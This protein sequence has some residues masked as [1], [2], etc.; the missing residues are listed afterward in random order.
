[1]AARGKDWKIPDPSADV[2]AATAPPGINGSPGGAPVGVN[3]QGQSAM[4][5][6]LMGRERQTGELVPFDI[7]K[8]T[9]ATPGSVA[10]ES[11]PRALGAGS[12]AASLSTL[13][14]AGRAYR[15]V[16][17]V[18]NNPGTTIQTF[19]LHVVSGSIDIVLAKSAAL[20]AGKTAIFSNIGLAIGDVVKGL[21]SS[22]M[23]WGVLGEAV[24]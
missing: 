19:E 1:M 15:K 8:L 22:G 11:G 20:R 21:T 23:T 3:Q 17:I 9:G 16:S 4:S 6:V 7:D 24:P 18:V 10:D 14:T 13:I 5:V 2:A 12:L